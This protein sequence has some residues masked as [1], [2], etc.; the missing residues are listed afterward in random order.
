MVKY[1]II[2]CN[3]VWFIGVDKK[4]NDGTYCAVILPQYIKQNGRVNV[5]VSVDNTDGSGQEIISAAGSAGSASTNK[6]S[7]I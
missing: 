4:V 1:N 7:G 3:C 5:R 2:L 6:G